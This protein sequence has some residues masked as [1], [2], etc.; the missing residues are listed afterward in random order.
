MDLRVGGGASCTGSAA[1]ESPDIVAIVIVL[2]LSFSSFLIQRARNASGIEKL[3]KI[4]HFLT[5]C[6]KYEKAGGDVYTNYS[7]HTQ[8]LSTG[9]LFTRRRW[10]SGHMLDGWLKTRTVSKTYSLALHGLIA[11]TDFSLMS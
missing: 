3:R 4:S 2:E 5:P 8:V 6:E 9:I 1:D 10:R 7:C 11:T